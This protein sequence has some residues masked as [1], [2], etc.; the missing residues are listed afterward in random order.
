MEFRTLG[1]LEVWDAGEPVRVRGMVQRSVLALLLLNANAVV[2]I[3]DLVDEVWG[4]SAP[5]SAGKMVQNAVSK[6]RQNGFAE[7]LAT[8]P[9]GYVLRIDPEQIDSARFERLLEEARAALAADKPEIAERLLEQ[10]NALWRG[11]PLADLATES[12]AQLEIARLEELRLDAAECAVEAGLALGRHRELATTLETLVALHPLRETLRVQLM[13]SLYRSGRQAEALATYQAARTYLRDE[14]GL[15]PSPALQR[16]EQA[17]LVQDTA[18]ELDVLGAPAMATHAQRKTLTVLHAELTREG[19][20]LD[21]EAL[22]A[23]SARVEEAVAEAVAAHGGTVSATTGLTIVAVFGLPKLAEDDTL[24]AA[25]AALDAQSALGVL[26]DSLH[27][28]WGVRCTLR[29]GIATGTALVEPTGAD[30]SDATGE[31]FGVAARLAHAAGAGEV[32]LARSTRRTLRDGVAVESAAELE[33]G[34]APEAVSRL[35]AVAPDATTTPRRSDIPLIGRDWELAQLRHALE[36]ATDAKTSYLV[37]ILGPAGI[38]KSRLAREFAEAVTDTTSVLAGRCPSYGVG[39]TF[40]PLAEIVR[41][42]AGATTRTAIAS[43]LGDEPESEEIAARIAGAIGADEPAGSADDLFFAVR[44]LF[45]ARARERPLVIVLD[46]LQWAEPTFVDLIEHIVD[47]MRDAPV[48]LL[49]LA[50]SEL[51]ET[52]PTW[53]GGKRNAS[54]ILL[55]PLSQSDQELLIAHAGGRSLDETVAARI[56]EAAEGNPLFLEQMVAMALEGGQAAGEVAVPPTI[57][58]LLAARLDRLAPL[59]RAALERASVAGKEFW[60]SEVAA[61]S[62]AQER[63]DVQQH[64]EALTRRELLGPR[65]TPRSGDAGF[66]FRHG[67]IRDAAYDALPKAERAA[68]HEE[69]ARFLERTPE[70]PVGGHDEVLG[71]HLERAYGYRVEL[72]ESGA[73]MRELAARAATLLA[74]AGRRAYA[75]DDVPAAVSLLERAAELFGPGTRARLELL[76]DLGEAVREGGDYP[77][78]EAVLAE[79]IAS[80]ADAGDGALEEYARLVRLRMRVQT[81]VGLGADEVVAGAHRAL[82]AFGAGDDG[83]SLAKAWELLAWGQWLQC[84]AAATEDA[85]A[86]A[87]EH[88]R[89]AGDERTEAQSL[90]LLL[91]AAVFGPCPV[92]EGIARCEAILADAG[93]QKRVTASALRALAAL[94]A[95]A[96]D[97]DE[98]RTLLRRF[99]SIVED[100]GLRVTAASAAETYAAVELLAGDAAAAERQLRSGYD[101]L[102]EMGESSTRVN[103]AAL[104]AQALHAQ[105]RHGEAVAV[106][107]VTPAED[108]VSAHVH[109]SAARAGALASVGR[110][111]EAELLARDAVERARTTDFLVMRGD[112]VSELADILR[113]TG[114]GA[115]A[116]GLLEEALELYRRKQHRVAIDR[117]VKAIT[118][119]VPRT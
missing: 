12:F 17:I 95:M 50:R 37:T 11:P 22:L 47:V 74:S 31:V 10:A 79:A 2:G 65:A 106:S 81:D 119:L 30:A 7:L 70:P 4:P 108:D 23:L 83:H 28:D 20:V 54:M 69:L 85:L 117:T 55:E 33:L 91:G 66:R 56:A 97:F 38:G 43:L 67:L 105:G 116:G 72:G 109:L 49:C 24:R 86:H 16:L 110:L 68:L 99:S 84:H 15:E 71:F 90:H 18:L 88:A 5:Q 118:S 61:L 40:W 51:L 21:P 57:Q 113:R 58:A 64:L 77:L 89:R 59:E 29:I 93:R 76:P 39:V 46:D 104:L 26:N 14:L 36:R 96:G 27:R 73:E 62:P 60:R 6:L 98:A 25:R 94:K 103:L 34:G 82:D 78:A 48:L 80:A 8:R 45:A 114:R 13:L 52:R 115:A 3:E 42:A 35:L 41:E 53:G 63:D 100:L 32:L 87:L 44:R 102:V 111:E 92:P 107:D 19:H 1:E 9:P 75:R 101:E 112:A